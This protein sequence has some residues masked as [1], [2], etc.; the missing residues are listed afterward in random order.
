MTG[1]WCFLPSVQFNIPLKSIP[2]QMRSGIDG[3]GVYISRSPTCE[4][5]R[6][7]RLL[8][9]G[10]TRLYQLISAREIDSF[11]DGGSRKITTESIRKYIERQ[12]ATA[13]AS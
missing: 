3:Y 11:A 7:C 13:G 6:G 10:R 12:L 5:A 1:G 9:C 4:T 2:P 8:A